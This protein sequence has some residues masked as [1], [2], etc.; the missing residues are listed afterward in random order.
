MLDIHSDLIQDLG[1]CLSRLIS[2]RISDAVK[3][4]HSSTQP[5]HTAQNAIDTLAY[6]PNLWF[7]DSELTP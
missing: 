5:E 6:R 4:R 2:G 3:V 1:F 7:P